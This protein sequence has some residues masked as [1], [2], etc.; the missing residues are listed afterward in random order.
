[1][2]P[3]S[4]GPTLGAPMVSASVHESPELPKS[5]SNGNLA[6]NGLFIIPLDDGRRRFEDDAH[7]AG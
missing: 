3:K 7:S 1:M 2:T 4:A 6:L 5:V